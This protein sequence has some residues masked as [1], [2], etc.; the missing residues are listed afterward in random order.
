MPLPPA[1]QLPAGTLWL[2]DNKTYVTKNEKWILWTSTMNTNEKEKEFIG[3]KML[4]PDYVEKIKTIIIAPTEKRGRGRPPKEKSR[5]NQ[6][7]R[8]LTKYTT[9]VQDQM[10]SGAFAEL[11]GQ[12]RLTK[13]SQLW[14]KAA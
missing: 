2:H 6:T 3:K 5:P 9:F 1:N 11:S 13:I 8:A 7:P 4:I 14:N 10:N 12:E